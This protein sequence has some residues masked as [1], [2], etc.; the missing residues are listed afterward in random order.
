MG[1]DDFLLLCFCF[2]RGIHLITLPP[3]QGCQVSFIKIGRKCYKIRSK[4]VANVMKFGQNWSFII[5]SYNIDNSVE[6]K[7]ILYF[8]LLYK[9][10]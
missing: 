2:A 4:S 6:I 9:Y 3:R 1:L 10:A 8:S 5:C 7:I